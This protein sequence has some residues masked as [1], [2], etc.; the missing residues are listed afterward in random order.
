[1]VTGRAFWPLTPLPEVLPLPEPRPRPRRF[2]SLV[3][4][5]FGWRLCNVIDIGKVPGAVE[6]GAE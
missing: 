3:A 1:M 6:L 5:S 2:L 4:P